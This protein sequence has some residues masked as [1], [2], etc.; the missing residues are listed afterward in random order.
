MQASS[1]SDEAPVNELTFNESK[2]VASGL[3]AARNWKKLKGV[4]LRATQGPDLPPHRL[5]HQ[6]FFP[7]LLPWRH[8]PDSLTI[9]LFLDQ[10]VTYPRCRP[11]TWTLI[12]RIGGLGYQVI[13]LSWVIEWGDIPQDDWGIVFSINK[14]RQLLLIVPPPRRRCR[15]TRSGVILGSYEDGDSS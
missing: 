11:I 13:I 2:R 1:R 8:C 6:D 12:R 3:S 9:F 5:P 4:D 10:S 7:Q 14:S 15:L